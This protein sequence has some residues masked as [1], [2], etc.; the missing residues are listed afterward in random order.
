[1]L[2][3]PEAAMRIAV[4]LP[5]LLVLAACASTPP[6]A[7]TVDPDHWLRG[8]A[9]P[10]PVAPEAFEYAASPE[11]PA[12]ME[13]VADPAEFPDPRAPEPPSDIPERPF[14]SNQDNPYGEGYDGYDGYRGDGGRR[15]GG[16]R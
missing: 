12:D 10:A 7:S 3:P 9:R 6:P 14:W 5:G 8:V 1:M 4:L 13:F 2:F 11:W 16:P 15:P